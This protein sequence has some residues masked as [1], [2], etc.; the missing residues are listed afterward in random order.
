MNFH[1]R[2][3]PSSIFSIDNVFWLFDSS[4]KEKKTL[5]SDTSPNESKTQKDQEPEHGEKT[6][7][8]Q[9][10]PGT[11]NSDDLYALP[12]K[13]KQTEVGEVPP[14]EDDADDD[15]PDG[16]GARDGEEKGKREDIDAIEDKDKTNDLPPG[17]EKHEGR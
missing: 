15:E 16:D 7:E 2:A 1:R 8:I 11:L 5:L 14:E 3:L 17:W 6:Q 12:N 13:R 9:H 10:I 4:P